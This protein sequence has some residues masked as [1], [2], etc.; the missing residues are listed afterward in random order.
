MLTAEKPRRGYT[1]RDLQTCAER[2]T[3]FRR[4]VYSRR[5]VKGSMTPAQADAEIDKMQAIAEHFAELAERE[6]LL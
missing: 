1:M 3:N 6:R 4:S 2:E 5:V